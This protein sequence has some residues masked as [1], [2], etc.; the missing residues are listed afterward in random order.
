MRLLNYYLVIYEKLV[1][2]IHIFLFYFLWTCEWELH[3]PL[4]WRNLNHHFIFS[5]HW[6]TFQS[7]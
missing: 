2:E 3:Y 5:P 4:T 7:P 6:Q 1:Y